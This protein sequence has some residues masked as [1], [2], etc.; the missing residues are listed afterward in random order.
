MPAGADAAAQA[1]EY[2]LR[3]MS[4]DE[5]IEVFTLPGNALVQNDRIDDASAAS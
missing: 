1:P 3:Q 4:A 5:Q 2:P